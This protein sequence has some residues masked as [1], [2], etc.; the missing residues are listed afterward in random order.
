MEVTGG[1][2]V[3][4]VPYSIMITPPKHSGTFLQ[5]SNKSMPRFSPEVV[6]GSASGCWCGSSL[7]DNVYNRRSDGTVCHN[8]LLC[9][10]YTLS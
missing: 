8:C 3:S 7:C 1:V 2:E 9:T 6:L 5:K 10:I 4:T